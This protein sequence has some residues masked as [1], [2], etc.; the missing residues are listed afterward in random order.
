MLSTAFT[1]WSRLIS[2]NAL[3]KSILRSPS[4]D[5]RCFCRVSRREWAT[6]STPP[7][8]PTPKFL[9]LKAA[10]ISSLPATQKHLATSLRRGSPQARG[11]TADADFSRAMDT[12]PATKRLKTQVLDLLQSR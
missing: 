12:P 3:R 11:R 2:L 4:L 6:T 10:E 1:K 7:G 9:P 5:A 8:H